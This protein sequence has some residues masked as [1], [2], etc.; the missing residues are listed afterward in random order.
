M[1]EG[2]RGTTRDEPGEEE[3]EEGNETTE[4]ERREEEEEEE[5]MPVSE[6]TARTVEEQTL[7]FTS[8]AGKYETTVYFDPQTVAKAQVVHVAD[9]GSG[10]K[11]KMNVFG[12]GQE[13]KEAYLVLQPHALFW[14]KSKNSVKAKQVFVLDSYRFE[15][16][17]GSYAEGQYPLDVVQKSRYYSYR[18]YMPN[19]NTRQEWADALREQ[20]LERWKRW[21]MTERIKATKLAAQLS[22]SMKD[23]E[24]LRFQLAKAEGEKDDALQVL[25]RLEEAA[26]VAEVQRE[27]KERELRESIQQ[28]EGQLSTKCEEADSLDRDLGDAAAELHALSAKLED[29]ESTCNNLESQMVEMKQCTE[30]QRLQ[31]KTLDATMAA[32]TAEVEQLK[33]LLTEAEETKQL[34]L[35]ELTKQAEELKLRELKLSSLQQQHSET[36]KKLEL[37]NSQVD[38]LQSSVRELNVSV[39]EAEAEQ[40]RLQIAEARLLTKIDMLEKTV[41]GNK[42]E[43]DDILRKMRA[44]EEEAKESQIGAAKVQAE[45][46]R[47]LDKQEAHNKEDSK[48]VEELY[49]EKRKGDKLRF[50]LEAALKSSQQLQSTIAGQTTKL[51]TLRLTLETKDADAASMKEQMRTEQQRCT[52]LEAKLQDCNSRIAALQAENLSL[53]E[54]FRKV[55][56]N[57]L[58]KTDAV[59]R[60]EARTSAFDS[61]S[62]K[63]SHEIQTVQMLLAKARSEIHYM[64][65]SL[66]SKSFE[67]EELR[68]SLENGSGTREQMLAENSRLVGETKMLQ[69]K[70]ARL[71]REKSEVQSELSSKEARIKSLENVQS[72]LAEYEEQIRSLREKLMTKNAELESMQTRSSWE[73]PASNSHLQHHHVSHDDGSRAALERVSMDN[74]KLQAKLKE[75]EQEISALRTQLSKT[76]EAQL[77]KEQKNA[78]AE[79]KRLR[80]AQQEA[81]AM[82][83]EL[84]SLQAKNK[85]N[86]ALE[87]EYT[88]ILEEIQALERRERERES[89]ISAVKAAG[90]AQNAQIEALNAK[91]AQAYSL[92]DA[93]IEKISLQESGKSKAP[94]KAAAPPAESQE[95]PRVAKKTVKKKSAPES[96]IPQAVSYGQYRGATPAY[97]AVTTKPRSSF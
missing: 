59:E 18:F 17:P 48:L 88:E 8:L 29:K 23:A 36:E 70:N 52:L 79:S 81:D 57:L 63:Q 21:T 66:N 62:T 9:G 95:L 72:Q 87:K 78:V 14:F 26:R 24:S 10:W 15:T 28:L 58:E 12:A 49:E 19:E 30:E 11:A 73:R 45:M 2:T 20:S 1:E 55:R 97:G 51:E 13:L 41:A 27:E 61:Y 38:S 67:L 71:Q 80:N 69:D 77:A 37:A 7:P 54:E 96:M 76:T 91:L 60:L 84:L 46:E 94:K 39:R 16:P 75:T 3:R 92:L 32:R 35:Q 25:E 33:T 93:K 34:N 74:E 86:Q 64:E 4:D 68:R 44:A 42:E 53:S 56:S 85:S 83:R 65:A 22:E 5:T 31:L 82:K 43:K 90:V 6:E 47:L 40:S 89:D 50:D